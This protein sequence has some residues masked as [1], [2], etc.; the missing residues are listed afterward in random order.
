M[1]FDKK[2]KVIWF[3]ADAGYISR[4]DVSGAKVAM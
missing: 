3:G 2:T 4:A 1:V